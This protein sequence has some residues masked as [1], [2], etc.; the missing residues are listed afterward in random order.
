MGVFGL[1]AGHLAK[2]AQSVLT[3]DTHWGRADWYFVAAYLT[4]ALVVPARC[5]LAVWFVRRFVDPRRGSG[6]PSPWIVVAGAVFLF[7]TADF[8]APFRFVD[9]GREATVLEWQTLTYMNTMA[10]NLL[11]PEGSVVGSW[12]S[13]VVGYFSRFPVVNLDGLVNS[14]DYLRARKEGTDVAFRQRYGITHLANGI[15]RHVDAT[16]LEELVTL[17]STR[18]NKF[19]I[20][21]P[22]GKSWGG[23]DRATWV[24]ERLEPHLERRA[25]GVGLLVNGRLAQ[26]FVRDCAPDELAVMELGGGPGGAR[27][28]DA[29][30]RRDLRQRYHAAARRPASRAGDDGGRVSGGPDRSGRPRRPARRPPLRLDVR[31]PD[32]T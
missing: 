30:G 6:I 13:G 28:V 31:L 9:R 20:W 4:G 5:C 19:R 17:P 7:A 14:R 10:M 22:A 11:L 3:V 29:N 21:L 1:A 27:P 24:R 16:L 26:A 18:R 32:D 23:A 12:D 8:T 15:S 25:D 2:F